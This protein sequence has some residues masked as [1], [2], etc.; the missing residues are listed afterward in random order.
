MISIHSDS[1]TVPSSRSTG[2]FTSISALGSVKGKKPGRKRTR[3]LR[4]KKRRAN[5]ARVALNS[6]KSIPSSTARPSICMNAAAWVASIV[7]CR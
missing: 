6:R 1:S 2:R 4:P 5:S 3:V 7:S